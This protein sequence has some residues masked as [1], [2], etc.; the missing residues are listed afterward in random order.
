FNEYL[1]EDVTEIV[2]GGAKGIDTDA[3]TFAKENNIKTTVFL[4]DYSRYGRGA[5]ILR[6][7]Q[8]VDYADEVL[9]FWDGKSKGTKSVIDYCKKQDKKVTV[10]EM[11]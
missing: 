9:A 2:S 4:P 11:P 8:I 1:P 6:N 10:V 7:Y 5:P 3:E